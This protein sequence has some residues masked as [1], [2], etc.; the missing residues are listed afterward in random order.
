[1]R[2]DFSVVVNLNAALGLL[3]LDGSR[4]RFGD[5]DLVLLSLDS[6]WGSRASFWVKQPMANTA[7]SNLR[8]ISF[9]AKCILVYTFINASYIPIHRAANS[10]VQDIKMIFSTWPM[11]LGQQNS[12]PP[13]GDFPLVHWGIQLE[14]LLPGCARLLDRICS[15][16]S[17]SKICAVLFCMVIANCSKAPTRDLLSRSR[18]GKPWKTKICKGLWFLNFT[19]NSVLNNGPSK[20]TVTHLHFLYMI[21]IW[22]NNWIDFIKFRDGPTNT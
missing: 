6:F 22:Q 16:R 18:P 19:A 13:S 9:F 7:W 11:F 20:R 2:L 14:V 10:L 4:S 21:R 1:M 12:I 3:T 5:L 17:I 8:W 15:P